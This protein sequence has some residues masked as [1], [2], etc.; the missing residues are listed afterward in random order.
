MLFDQSGRRKDV[1]GEHC[2]MLEA[3]FAG[4]PEPF[5]AFIGETC[6]QI[7]ESPLSAAVVIFPEQAAQKTGNV[8]VGPDVKKVK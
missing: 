5:F 2:Q 8:Q 4:L 3:S 1:N 7:I 6:P